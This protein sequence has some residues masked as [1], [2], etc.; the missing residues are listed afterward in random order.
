MFYHQM[1]E[2]VYH[3]QRQQQI[4]IYDNYGIMNL[5]SSFTK[6]VVSNGN[7]NSAMPPFGGYN[8][9][10]GSR[11]RKRRVQDVYDNSTEPEESYY[12]SVAANAFP[13]S[14]TPFNSLKKRSEKPLESHI[15]AS[16]LRKLFEG[17]HRGPNATMAPSNDL[18]CEDCDNEIPMDEYNLEP[19][20]YSCS[21]CRRTVCWRCSLRSQEYGNL[22]EC[23]Q[24]V[25]TRSH[26]AMEM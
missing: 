26:D 14:R 19:E 17:A 8:N 24:C 16:T 25:S 4:G 5:N 18:S 21:S 1:Q 10:G 23:L 11:S 22:L 13:D 12:A 15:H 7:Q 20:S 3:H 6:S 9:N 2:P